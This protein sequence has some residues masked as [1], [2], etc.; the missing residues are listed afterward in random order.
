MLKKKRD[1]ESPK[2]FQEAQPGLLGPSGQSVQL[3]ILACTISD[4]FRVLA[5]CFDWTVEMR[6][7]AIAS[8]RAAQFGTGLESTVIVYGTQVRPKVLGSGCNEMDNL[9]SHGRL[10]VYS[11]S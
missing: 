9:T 2:R 11:S 6:G 1:D 10:Q 3:P 4:H 7:E 5:E 8:T